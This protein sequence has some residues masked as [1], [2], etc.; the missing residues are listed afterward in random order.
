M[1]A[2]LSALLCLSACSLAAA[3]PFLVEDGQAR[4]EIVIAEKPSRTVRVAAQELQDGIRKISGAH[5]PIVTQPSGAAVKLHVGRSAHTD[6]LKI[7]PE[8]LKDGA[9][10]LVSGADWMVFL[11]D[12]AEFTPIEPWAKSNADIVSGKLQREWDQITGALWGAPQATLYKNRFSVPGQTGLP[13]AERDPAAKLPPLEMW[14]FDER[15]SFN[16]VCGFLR[17][18]GAR[19]YAPGELGEVLPAM[20]S[21][22]LPVIDETVRPDFPVRRFNIRMGVYG[23]DMA[24]WAMRLGL[25]DPYGVGV[26]HGLDDMTHRDE[27]FAKHPE[28]FALYG[29][30]RHNQPGQRLNQ[31]CY[32]NEELFQET[33]RNVRAQIDHYQLDVVSVMPPDGYTSI[34]Q[35]P[36]CEGKDSPE[37]D[38][39]GLLSDYVWDF[40]NR[41][42]REVRKTHPDKKII[43]CAYGVYTL[44]PLK[45]EKLEPNVVV[46]IVGGRRPVNNRPE[47]QKA[48]R[49]LRDA[50]LKKTDNPLINFEN[51][52]FT[53]RGWYLPAYTP[54][55]MG[56]S[57]NA[58]KGTFEG[59]DIWLSVR[60]DF[61]KVGMGFNHFLIY[62]TQRMYWGGRGQDVGAM[63]REYVRLFY[64]PAEA[65]MLAFFEY[66]ESNWQ[67]MEK[68]KAKADQALG[69]FSAA[70]KK[71]APES[72]HG[73]RLALIDDFLKG[74]RSKSE[75]LGRIRGP[76]P[77]LRLVGEARGG[78]VIDGKLDEDAWEK[79]PTASTGRLR[80]LQTGRQ[81]VFGTSVK[82][83]WIGNDVY[84]AIRCEEHPG[85]KVNN[86]STKEDDSALWY[87]D[88]V[89]VL[90]ETDARSYYQIAVSP[91]GVVA[92]LDRS[93]GRSAWF[94]WDSQ[95]EVATHIADDHWIVEMRVPVTQDENDPLH[96][97]IGRKPTKSLPWHIN[98]CRQRIRDDGVEHSAFSPSGA[99]HF[100]ESMKFAHFFDGNS[101]Q[102][103]AAEPD[104]DF[105]EAMRVASDFAR[106]GQ[107]E[108][109]LAAY[110]T[111]ADG[112]I[113]AFQKS[114]ALEQAVAMA[115]SLRRPEVAT[116]LAGRIPIEA[117]GKTAMMQ[118]LI[119]QFAAA[120]V[121]E[122]FG[123]EDIGA[124]PFWQRGAG[125]HARGRALAITK[126]GPEAEADLR[127]ALEWTS[128]P[129]LR[130]AI[131]QALGS[132]RE[133]QLK[134]DDGA[135]AAYR[136]IVATEGQLGSADQ[137]TALQN[138]AR[139]LIRRGQTAEAVATLRRVDIDAMRGF[140]HGSLGL[141][142]GQA[143]A[144]G[145]LKDEA[146][147]AY[148]GVIA[149]E[150]TDARQRKTAEEAIAALEK[151]D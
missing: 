127:L 114:A 105:L 64:G 74:L 45:I 103:D 92:D 89:E 37:R 147:T 118:N 86:A 135:L 62:F 55:S 126:A 120:R 144:A 122:Q 110:T 38:N 139:I 17:G 11:G 137:F 79:C 32:S 41:V 128:E 94:S 2:V 123:Q 149:D 77:T 143:L 49:E 13:D 18:L 53:D 47:E 121:V 95:A 22:P 97:V 60:Q 87:G 24:M 66:C 14:G 51:Y 54:G 106:K 39:R 88:A 93:A 75:Q 8:G 6:A 132:N 133:M 101:F 3:G 10:R 48:M 84:F 57:I 16:A 1:K 58:I 78:I 71:A 124:W 61:E 81:P 151:G 44:P 15:G 91:S 140:W 40:V 98:I 99:E 12:D 65:E 90:L 82:A 50:W 146:V 68:D 102:F 96:Q 115:R 125:Y 35:C 9:Y 20:K 148:R 5:L 112:K 34:C 72:V 142:L 43:N 31:L 67:D 19:W 116:E 134:D 76:V 28:W 138:I 150:A 63:F 27:I 108:E 85:E 26:A 83:A 36:L 145:G 21:I 73:R 56:E 104:A 100:H 59:E 107:R 119:E 25:R 117:V 52:P 70:L 111:A 109:A 46:S 23:P 29:G 113:S 4:A 69:L 33:V 7:S 130:D 131:W 141:S 129:R 80:E 30:K 42:A 136:E